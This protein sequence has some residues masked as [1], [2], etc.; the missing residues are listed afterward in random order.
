MSFCGGEIALPDLPDNQNTFL[1][2][3]LELRTNLVF[4]TW[5]VARNIDSIFSYYLC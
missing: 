1:K 4:H 3:P 2:I 5:V